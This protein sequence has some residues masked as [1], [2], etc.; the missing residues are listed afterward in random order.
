M[1]TCVGCVG[2]VGCVW[3]GV[4]MLCV[5]VVG[6]YVCVVG[7]CP[8]ARIVC[9]H[10]TCVCVCVYIHACVVCVCVTG[11]TPPSRHCCHS[12]SYASV[13]CESLGNPISWPSHLP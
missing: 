12:L 8:C 3:G 13:C 6:V 10:C 1:C 5:G 2:C 7:G 9:I 4:G 11:V